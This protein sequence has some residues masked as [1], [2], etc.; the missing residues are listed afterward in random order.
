LWVVGLLVL[1]EDGTGF[2][3]DSALDAV[4]L[5]NLGRFQATGICCIQWSPCSEIRTPRLTQEH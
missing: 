1:S 2:A 3:T 5:V 4:L